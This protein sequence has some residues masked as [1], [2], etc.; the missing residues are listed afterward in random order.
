MAEAHQRALDAQRRTAHIEKEAALA[1]LAKQMRERREAEVA[2][3]SAAVSAGR[4]DVE[5]QAKHWKLLVEDAKNQVGAE[6]G[7]QACVH[8]PDYQCALASCSSASAC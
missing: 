2:A 7:S 6:G 3:L 4:A 1:L 8:A 5:A